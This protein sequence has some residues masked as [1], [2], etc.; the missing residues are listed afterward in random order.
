MNAS[1]HNLRWQKRI[2][3]KQKLHERAMK[4]AASQSKNVMVQPGAA[5][6]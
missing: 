2:A 6:S 5:L 1:P 4:L 3:R